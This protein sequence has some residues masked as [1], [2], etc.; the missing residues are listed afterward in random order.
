MDRGLAVNP[1]LA[2]AWLLS[3]WLK[4]WRGELDLALDHVAQAM[5][6]SPV[7]PSLHAMLAATAYAHR[8]AQVL[9][10]VSIFPPYTGNDLD[11]AARPL[12]PHAVG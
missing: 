6:L 5:R 11:D 1:N 12:R 8:D 3:S 9:V 7:D 2:Q 10:T 4:I